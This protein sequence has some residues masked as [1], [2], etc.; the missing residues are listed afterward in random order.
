MGAG[1]VCVKYDA[2]R[3]KRNMGKVPWTLP[4]PCALDGVTLF[5]FISGRIFILTL[6]LFILSRRYPASF[7][8]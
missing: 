5:L 4:N 6:L 8:Y 7:C 1:S 2:H 3:S